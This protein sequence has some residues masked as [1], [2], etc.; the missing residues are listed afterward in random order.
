MDYSRFGNTGI[1]AS[2]LSLG[3][4]TFGGKLDRAEC[5]RVVDEALDNGINLIDTA[6][7]YGDSEEILGEL[8]APE[9]REHVFLATKVYRRFCRD[10][11]VARNSCTNI[12]NSLDRSLRLLKTDYVDLYQLHHPDPDT[13]IDE[14]L[15][16]LDTIVRQGKARY[17]GVAN[18][19]AWQMAHMLGEAKGRGY[20]PIVSYQASY[21]ILDR[22]LEFDAVEF[23][24]KFNM[25]LMCYSPLS[26]GI[27]TGKYHTGK[28]IPEGSRATAMRYVERYLENETVNTIM[29]GL[30][31]IAAEQG[32]QLN[33][34]AILWLLAKSH[35]TTVILGGSR[36]EHFSQIYE[37]IGQALPEDVVE[38][39]DTLS[40]SRIYSPYINQNQRTAPAINPGA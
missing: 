12:L 21:S 23:V 33:Q 13:P 11:R 24:R 30:K 1:E 29:E 35:V 22:Q 26:S 40:E 37:I 19:Y 4:M 36:P 5:A 2:R 9:K 28:G 27:L 39:I 10:G 6:D 8:L 31:T 32:L 3:A 15:A 14:T 34:L 38:K 18:H 7:S 20:V 25:A 16:T 17:V